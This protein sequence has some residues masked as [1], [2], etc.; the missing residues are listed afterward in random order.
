MYPGTDPVALWRSRDWRTLLNLIDHLPQN[1]WYQAAVSE[2]VDHAVMLLDAM[3]KAKKDGRPNDGPPRP[4]LA[5]WSPEVDMLAKVVDNV[6][7][8]TYAVSK[9]NGGK[10]KEPT[11]VARPATGMER[12][13][14]RIKAREH[15]KMKARLLPP[16]Q[17]TDE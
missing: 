16:R 4:S 6:A 15:E 11:M 2:D 8:T 9:A 14:L 3:D 13:R 12:A 17:V 5:I 10:P 7:W 1:T